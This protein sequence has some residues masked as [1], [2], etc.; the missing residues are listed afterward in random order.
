[1]GAKGMDREGHV[2]GGVKGPFDDGYTKNVK[3]HNTGILNS[4]GDLLSFDPYQSR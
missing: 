2:I 1:M 3:T 4:A